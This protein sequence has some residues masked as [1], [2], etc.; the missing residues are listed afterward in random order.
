M[1]GIV[2]NGSVANPFPVR[3]F[4]AKQDIAVR[5]W[6][7]G[8]IAHTGFKVISDDQRVWPFPRKRDI[9]YH[10]LI[11]SMQANHHCYRQDAE[12]AKLHITSCALL[13]LD[14]STISLLNLNGDCGLLMAIWRLYADVERTIALGGR[15]RGSAH[16][17]P[18]DP[19]QEN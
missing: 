15:N 12:V 3:A 16:Q 4:D 8:K 14:L 18:H 17:A 13:F 11:A 9:V 1:V 19:K 7:R 6:R 2:L 10:N 5:Y